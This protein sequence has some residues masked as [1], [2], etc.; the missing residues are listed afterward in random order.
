MD[1][2]EC[3]FGFDW[4]EWLCEEVGSIM[5]GRDIGKVEVIQSFDMMTEPMVADVYVSYAVLIDGIFEEGKH[6]LV[7]TAQHDFGLGKVNK[8]AERV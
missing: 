4:G 8:H 2:V 3:L 7:V 6:P 5:V 1:V